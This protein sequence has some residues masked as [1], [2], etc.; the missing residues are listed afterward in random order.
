MLVAHE[1]FSREF[2]LGFNAFFVVLN[3][4]VTIRW[5]GRGLGSNQASSLMLRLAEFKLVQGF[6]EKCGEERRPWSRFSPER[7]RGPC[8]AS[9]ERALPKH[10]TAVNNCES[11]FLFFS[12]LFFFLSRRQ[13]LVP[14]MWKSSTMQ[15]LV[16]VKCINNICSRQ[17]SEETFGT[18][19]RPQRKLPLDL[20]IFSYLFYPVLIVHVATFRGHQSH[21]QT[22]TV[23]PPKQQNLGFVSLDPH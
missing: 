18:D 9:G 11:F 22:T 15:S 5:V 12:L 21:L 3:K 8:L 10:S 19:L 17:G 7:D 20:R 6:D 14:V 23:S 2:C 1:R 16:H 13:V 4:L